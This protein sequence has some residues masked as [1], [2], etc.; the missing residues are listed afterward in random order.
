M[1]EYTLTDDGRIHGTIR[2]IKRA[3]QVRLPRL[4][5][6]PNLVEDAVDHTRVQI[7]RIPTV[8]AFLVEILSDDS[9][10]VL[11]VKIRQGF[12]VTRTLILCHM[13]FPD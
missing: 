12:I 6:A 10:R 7:S 8:K 2:F 13:P 1:T 4:S 11:V 9:E 3:R 5:S